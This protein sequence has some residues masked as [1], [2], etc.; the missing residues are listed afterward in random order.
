MKKQKIN[1]KNLSYMFVNCDTIY[2]HSVVTLCNQ[3]YK[4]IYYHNL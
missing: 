1:N 4:F 2:L 3:T